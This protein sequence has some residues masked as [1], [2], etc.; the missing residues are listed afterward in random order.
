VPPTFQVNMHWHRSV[1][2]DPGNK[3]LRDMLLSNIPVLQARG[4]DRNGRRGRTAKDRA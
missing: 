2:N 1:N 4:Y 3:W